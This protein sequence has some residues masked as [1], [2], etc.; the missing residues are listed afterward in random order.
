MRF[1]LCLAVLMLAGCH[2]APPIITKIDSDPPGARIF[3]AYGTHV[4]TGSAL[5]REYVGSTPCTY[6]CPQD[7]GR[8][9]IPTGFLQ[10]AMLAPPLMIFY[11]EP[12]SSMT[13][14]TEKHQAFHG[15]GFGVPADAVPQGL[16][17]DL[18]K[19]D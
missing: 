7:G 16:F 8:L 12:A 6:T 18:T 4:V 9:V 1:S 10:K 2:T 15:K 17:F 13:N 3:V 19:T 5:G 14:A 11:A